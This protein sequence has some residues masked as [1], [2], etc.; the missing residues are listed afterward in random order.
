MPYFYG[1]ALFIYFKSLHFLMHWMPSI[2]KLT[3]WQQLALSKRKMLDSHQE[4]N[5][6]KVMFFVV[7]YAIQIIPSNC[8]YDRHSICNLLGAIFDGARNS[9][10]MSREYYLDYGCQ[11][12]LNLYPF[13]TQVNLI[14]FKLL[15]LLF[16]LNIDTNLFSSDTICN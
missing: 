16:E 7:I 5:L 3:A 8:I 13:D 15:S 1:N 14:D 12:N 2:Q 4:M 9:V 6:L 10:W 11:Y